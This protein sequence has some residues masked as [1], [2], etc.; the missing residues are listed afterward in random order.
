VIATGG[1]RVK[2]FL[3]DYL[4]VFTYLAA[5]SAV[6]SFLTF[7]PFAAQ[8]SELLSSPVKMDL[9]AFAVSVLPVVTYFALCESSATA[10]TWGKKRLGLQVL[11]PGGGR[12]SKGQGFG[13][14]LLKFLPWQMAHTAMLHIPGFPL[15]PDNPPGWTVA[16]LV[17]A[18]ALVAVYLVGLTSATGGRTAYDRLI[19][20]SVLVVSADT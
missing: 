9:F 17:S 6:G 2:A 19:G 10:A 11:D 1:S 4:L 5:L 16:L 8:W 12:L 13:R 20:S 3:Y 14:A 18:W 15:E 7:G